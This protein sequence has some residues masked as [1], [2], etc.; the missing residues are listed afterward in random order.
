MALTHKEYNRV[1]RLD[2]NGRV[3]SDS[4]KTLEDKLNELVDNGRHNIIVDLSGVEFISSAGMRAL[5]TGRKL[6]AQR[7]GRLVLLSPSER[8]ADVLN[9]TGLNSIFDSYDDPTEAVGSF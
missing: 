4:V 2:I 7:N 9:M 5:V 6:C 8:V 1:D 3:D